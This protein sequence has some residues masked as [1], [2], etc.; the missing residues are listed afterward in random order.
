MWGTTSLRLTTLGMLTM[1]VSL[2]WANH[3]QQCPNLKTSSKE[4]GKLEQEISCGR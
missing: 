1:P 4:Q 2:S 3:V